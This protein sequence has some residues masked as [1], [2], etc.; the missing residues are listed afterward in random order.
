MITYKIIILIS[1]ILLHI[2]EDFHLQG[3]LASMKQKKW[4]KNELIKSRTYDEQTWK[5]Y[6]NDYIV[7][8]IVHSLENSIFIMLPCIIDCLIYT[9][10]RNPYNHFWVY[11]VSLIVGNTIIHY[12]IDNLKANKMQINLVVDQ[13][14][15]LFVIIIWFFIYWQFLG[16]WIY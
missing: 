3:I 7:S 1:M 10:T 5:K 2:I 12:L 11:L 13:L 16:L 4:W 14:M 9:I 15:H 6:K 8:L